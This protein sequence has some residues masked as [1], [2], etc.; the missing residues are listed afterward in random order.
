MK[1]SIFFRFIL[2]LSFLFFVKNTQA[3]M[4][5]TVSA[6]CQNVFL[7]IAGGGPPYMISW[8]DGNTTTSIINTANYLYPLDGVYLIVVTDNAQDT[9]SVLV[10]AFACFPEI[11]GNQ[12]PCQGDCE[13]YYDAF[14]GSSGE[15]TIYDAFGN[16]IFEEFG[17]QIDFCWQVEAGD[18]TIILDTN[19]DVTE[20]IVT[21]SNPPLPIDIVSLANTFCQ[22]D[23][24]NPTSCE[25]ICANSTA[26]YTVPGGQDITWQVQGANSF[27]PNGNQVEVEWGEPG[28]GQITATM[29]NSAGSNLEIN[30]E[31]ALVEGD[32]GIYT[33][34]L[35]ATASGGNPPYSFSWQGPNGFIGTPTFSVLASPS[36][37][38]TYTASVVDASGVVQ[39]CTV[40]LAHKYLPDFN[41][42]CVAS[43]SITTQ[44]ASS[45][46]ATCDGT[47]QPD[48]NFVI[49]GLSGGPGSYIYAWSNGSTAQNLD[50]SCAGTYSVT[51]TEAEFGCAISSSAI[52]GCGNQSTC[53]S[54]TS[55]CIDILED[56]NANFSTIPAAT[57]GVVNI[58]EG[59]TVVFNN[60]SEGA[61][62]FEW[63]FGNGNI[64]T[65]TNTE[66]TYLTAGTYQVYL[67]SRNDCY[68]S[69]TTFLTVEVADAISPFLDC[70]GT[71]CEAETVTYT[72]DA[73]CGSF[74]WNVTGNYNILD[75]G[76]TTDDFIT[77]EW[78]SGPEGIIELT[79]AGCLGGN[80]CLEPMVAVIPIIS[81]DAVIK[82]PEKVCRMDES[83]YF[84]ND[85]SATDF[86]WTVSSGGTIL[87]GQNSSSIKV[88]WQG[89]IS[90][91]TPQWVAVDYTNCYLGCGGGDT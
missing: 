31:H 25:K 4:T 89:S 7:N 49:I 11:V 39:S 70:V 1:K 64:S 32:S 67:V 88:R 69:D 58:C 55:L 83:T 5:L 2:V 85:Y 35:D 9:A 22:A 90:P 78:L 8:G 16:I 17:A 43:L 12:A 33:L 37:A 82:G 68:C 75:G 29:V 18:Y 52:I 53:P 20:Y 87:E 44:D 48:V 57:N 30:C 13:T 66:Q 3:Q 74:S 46:N 47:A 91:N 80:Y 60:E 28:S 21:V 42:S 72:T 38:G 79:V 36:T 77:I 15:W 71:I 59:G 81:D 61:S 84:L 86:I 19:G 45:C 76:G 34:E 62:L 73:D 14:S 40:E 50:N 51:I 10:D 26:I 54:T 27:I 41:T 23:S 6:D 56:P 24:L 65:S 63:N